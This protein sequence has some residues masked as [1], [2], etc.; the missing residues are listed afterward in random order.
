VRRLSLRIWPSRTTAGRGARSDVWLSPVHLR[1]S[2]FVA[3]ASETT[4]TTFFFANALT[5]GALASTVA[6]F[7]WLQGDKTQRSRCVLAVMSRCWQDSRIVRVTA[8]IDGPFLSRRRDICRGQRQQMPDRCDARRQR[9]VV[10]TVKGAFAVVAAPS[11]VDMAIACSSPRWN[12]VGCAT[13]TF[14][15]LAAGTCANDNVLM[16]REL[17]RQVDVDVHRLNL[18][19]A[20]LSHGI[21]RLD[22]RQ[23][24]GRSGDCF[25]HRAIFFEDGAEKLV[26]IG[27]GAK[28]GW[29][30]A[31]SSRRTSPSTDPMSCRRAFSSLCAMPRGIV[32]R[33]RIRRVQF[34][35]VNMRGC[36]GRVVHV[37]R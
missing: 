37:I 2:I 32:P 5:R 12:A 8:K 20:V 26:H 13:R 31:R 11:I 14:A 29:R 30:R 21:K 10:G 1:I 17:D 19:T 4:T 35:F 16:S 33:S 18:D 25:R 34:G 36:V 28:L 6:T 24:E 15:I 9:E 22:A 27:D 3:C 23:S 7:K